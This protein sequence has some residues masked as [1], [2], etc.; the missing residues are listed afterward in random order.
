[1]GVV[2]FVVWTTLVGFLLGWLRV[3]SNSVFPAALG[4]GAINA[5]IA[6]GTF[7][8]PAPDEMMT[9]PFG[10][11]AILALLIIALLV[12]YDLRKSTRVLTT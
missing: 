4:H 9:I 5:Y 12:Y 6:F 8:A 7:I 10:V 3:K 11:P 2:A 1:M